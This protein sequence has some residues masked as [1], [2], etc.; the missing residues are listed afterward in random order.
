MSVLTA[1]TL[2]SAEYIVPNRETTMLTMIVQPRSTKDVF[3]VVGHSGATVS[4]SSV[5][6]TTAQTTPTPT[7]ITAVGIQ[8]GPSTS[9]TL[10][11][12]M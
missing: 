7:I 10:N 2:S 12:P 5:V 6:E 8:M 11:H 9:Q 4:V 3:T 1:D